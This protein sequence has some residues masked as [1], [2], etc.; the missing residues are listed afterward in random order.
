MQKPIYIEMYKD[1]VLL[2]IKYKTTK[3]ITM[4]ATQHINIFLCI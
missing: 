2:Q 4:L 3:Y 1:R